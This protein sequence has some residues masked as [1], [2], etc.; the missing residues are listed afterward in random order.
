MK[1]LS[2]RQ[3]AS[4]GS[5]ALLSLFLPACASD[6]HINLFGYTTA[7]NYDYHDPHGLRADGQE[8]DAVARQHRI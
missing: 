8:P 3:W 7:P 5:M 1:R 2:L 6:G 4:L